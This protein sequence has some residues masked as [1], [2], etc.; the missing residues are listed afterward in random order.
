MAG[1]ST[2][3]HPLVTGEKKKKKGK[4]KEKID[5]LSIN[6]CP[7][8]GISMGVNLSIWEHWLNGH[9]YEFCSNS[10]GEHNASVGQHLVLWSSFSHLLIKKQP[11]KKEKKKK[12]KKKKKA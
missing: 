7:Q 1:W 10:M 6:K 11:T 4:E 8:I 9:L 2:R 5:E 12:E 3:E